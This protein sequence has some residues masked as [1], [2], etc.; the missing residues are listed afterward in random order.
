MLQIAVFRKFHTELDRILAHH[1][2][3]FHNRISTTWPTEPMVY[4]G[5]HQTIL[6]QRALPPFMR[7]SVSDVS[8]GLATVISDF[9]G[10]G[11]LRDN[12]KILAAAQTD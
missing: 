11:V 3:D 5:H 7:V 1:L 2:H 8:A 4:F 10:S 6:G 12:M 9:V